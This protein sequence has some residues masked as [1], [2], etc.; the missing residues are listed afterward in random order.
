MLVLIN[1]V[2]GLTIPRIDNAAHIG[3]LVTG[4]WIGAIVAPTRV[5]TQ[6][7]VFR[8]GPLAPLAQL[9]LF[10]PVLAVVVVAI[11]VV[12][13]LMVGTAERA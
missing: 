2:F 3:G 9:P 11:V 1:I 4:L 6:S 8:E 5:E 13:G 7:T 10:A 12:A